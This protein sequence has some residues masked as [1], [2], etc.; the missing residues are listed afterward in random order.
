MGF[1]L[2]Y[3]MSFRYIQPHPPTH[4]RLHTQIYHP[5]HQ[6]CSIFQEYELE[7]KCVTSNLC[8]LKPK[9]IALPRSVPPRHKNNEYYVMSVYDYCWKRTREKSVQTINLVLFRNVQIMSEFDTLAWVCNFDIIAFLHSSWTNTRVDDDLYS[10][11]HI[12]A[13][14][15]R[16]EIIM[17]KFII[18]KPSLLQ[19]IVE[20]SSKSFG[21]SSSEYPKQMDFI[22]FSLAIAVHD[23][24][25]KTFSGSKSIQ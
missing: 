14:D 9:T 10:R 19:L 21:H 24:I 8:V 25:I 7:L 17:L 18:T 2:Y 13:A 22:S 1:S 20:H 16:I 5:I 4:T 11:F 12:A 3:Q 15:T 6:M 23:E